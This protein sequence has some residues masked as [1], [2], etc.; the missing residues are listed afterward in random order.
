MEQWLPFGLGFFSILKVLY[1]R[2]H[3]AVGQQHQRVLLLSMVRGNDVPSD[4]G[5]PPS[6]LDAAT[7]ASDLTLLC[8]SSQSCE[9]E[10]HS[11]SALGDH[12]KDKMRR[13]GKLSSRW[14]D[15]PFNPTPATAITAQPFIFLVRCETFPRQ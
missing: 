15:K 9:A 5:I 2:L 7:S 8:F 10:G 14:F 11:N 1:Q 13:H 12:R 3:T 4:H 6:N